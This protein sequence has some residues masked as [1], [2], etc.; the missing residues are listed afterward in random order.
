MKALQIS[1]GGIFEGPLPCNSNTSYEWRGSSTAVESGPLI[2]ASMSG[3][4]K[5]PLEK[6]K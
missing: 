3:L 2:T 4:V 6:F 5:P 1:H